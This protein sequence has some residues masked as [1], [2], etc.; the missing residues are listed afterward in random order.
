MD[1]DTCSE[2]EAN[3]ELTNGECKAVKEEEESAEFIGSPGFIALMSVVGVVG[4]ALIG[5]GVYFGVKALTA[6]GTGPIQPIKPAENSREPI[7]I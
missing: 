7:Q 1:L 4:A 2:C 3:Y 6:A 5:V